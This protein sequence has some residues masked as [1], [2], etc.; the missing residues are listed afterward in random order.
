LR[1]AA[2]SEPRF[3]NITLQRVASFVARPALHTAIKLKLHDTLES[4]TRRQNIVVVHG[5]GGAGKSQLVVNYVQEFRNDYSGIFWIDVSQKE[6][7]ERQYVQLY[8][9]LFDIRTANDKDLPKLEDLVLFV[10]N[11]FSDRA[12]RYLLVF[13]GADNIDNPD[14]SSFVDIAKFIPQAWIVDVLITTRCSSAQYFPEAGAVE[15]QKMEEQE[16]L[17]LLL[18]SSSLAPE[19]VESSQM[20]QAKLI[21]EE[22]GFLPLAINLAGSYIS[23][24]PRLRSDL[25]Q[26]LPEYHQ[27]RRIL[28]SQKPSQLIHQYGDSVLNTW[29]TS[30]QAIN[31]K[32]P[33][34]SNL[35]ILMAFLESDD[36]YL[37]FFAL[38]T[39]ENPEL[40]TI[41]SDKSFDI[42]DIEEAFAV[43][44]SFSLVRWSGSSY[45]M[46]KLVHAWG[47]DRLDQQQRFIFGRASLE[48]L[49]AVIRN[50]SNFPANKTRLVPHV[51]ANFRIISQLVSEDLAEGLGKVPLECLVDFGSFFRA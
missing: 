30:F 40:R 23:I 6:S 38:A 10:R 8:R 46:H 44:T 17:Y 42:H 3:F 28:L 14:D 26:Y 29:E 21:V 24:T 1:A 22:L 16:A 9:L 7:L 39:K 32:S 18:K 2:V 5:L 33:T 15:V 36:I 35:L 51:I 25:T 43:L 31:R 50:A 20:L 12:G 49:E 27:R 13:D 41:F 47:R 11:W 19:S 4:P 37:E 45:S 48:F 34:A